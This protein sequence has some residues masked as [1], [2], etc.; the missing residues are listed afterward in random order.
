MFPESKKA[1]TAFPPSLII[2][3]VLRHLARHEGKEAKKRL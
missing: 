1:G 3:L 2:R